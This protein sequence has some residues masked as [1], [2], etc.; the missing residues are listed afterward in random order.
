[1]YVSK[2]EEVG[3]GVGV[4]GVLS[5]MRTRTFYYLIKQSVNCV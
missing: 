4:V 3:V 5:L 1:M 2:S